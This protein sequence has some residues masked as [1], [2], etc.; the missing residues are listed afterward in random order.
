MKTIFNEYYNKEKDF[1]NYCGIEYVAYDK[2][3]YDVA[4]DN[5]EYDKKN[6][7]IDG[8]NFFQNKCPF[9]ILLCLS[10][11]DVSEFIRP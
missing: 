4:L 3:Y 9:L 2:E 10:L 8:N 7:E 11:S 6:D 1:K 5:D